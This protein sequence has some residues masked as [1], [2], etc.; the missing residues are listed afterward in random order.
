MRRLMALILIV[1]SPF[2]LATASARA[3]GTSPSIYEA[4][5]VVTGTGEKNH[6]IGFRLCLKQVLVKASGDQRV[7]AAPGLATAL[8]SAGS[9]VAS[10]RY[11]DRLA[12]IPVHDEQGTHDRPQDLTCLYKPETLDPL[13]ASLG[14]KPW[15]ANRPRLAV[16]LSAR[17]GANAFM[18]TGTGNT[19]FYMRDSFRMAAAALAIPIRF[20]DAA[21]LKRTHIDADN[22]SRTN[23]A[24]LDALA[25]ESGAAQ[26]LAGSIVWSENDLGWIAE[27]R[28]TYP[29]GVAIWHVKGVSFDEAFRN[30][31]RG[32]AQVLSGNGNP[33]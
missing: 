16:F 1:L 19:G 5:A 26:A 15:L 31:M 12:G 6:E 4:Q 20:P 25:K 13:L 28:V 8:A 22:L 33:S 10:F 17:H 21:N 14:T 32:A 30:A 23:M 27:W 24:I 7:L 9:Y 18:L 2:W 3:N 29:T 11:H